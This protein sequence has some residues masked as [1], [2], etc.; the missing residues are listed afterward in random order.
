MGGTIAAQ[1]PQPPPPFRRGGGRGGSDVSG[2]GF[3][4]SGREGRFHTGKAKQSLAGQQLPNV[5]WRA[6]PM[7]H[8]RAH[9]DYVGLPTSEDVVC[10]T[11]AHIARFQ[12]Q[13]EEWRAL[14]RG[15]CTTSQFAASIGFYER[16]QVF[17][18][19]SFLR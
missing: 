8:L 10:H 19:I 2:D 4:S 15:R 11:P 12:E 13:S 17:G 7:Q 16:Q 9:P 14:H 18:L 6:I 3:S 1:P 5:N